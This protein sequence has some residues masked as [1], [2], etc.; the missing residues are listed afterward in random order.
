[1]IDGEVIHV[2][3]S[4]SPTEDHIEISDTEP[5]SG[6]IEIL[7]SDDERVNPSRSHVSEAIEILDDDPDALVAGEVGERRRV[8]RG[9]FNPLLPLT[10]SA[11][12]NH[13]VQGYPP[14]YRIARLSSQLQLNYSTRQRSRLALRNVSRRP[15]G[16]STG[17]AENLLHASHRVLR[18]LL[19]RHPNGRHRQTN[20]RRSCLHTYPI[21]P[22]TILSAL[23]QAG[24]T[25]PSRRQS[26][27]TLIRS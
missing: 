27:T 24:R 17:G 12:L 23:L 19:V 4:D 2:L 21:R 1:M 7:D 14:T 22:K 16:S 11:G 26:T 5:V 15:S 13:L 9:Q 18:S 3:D 10:A 6:P 20:G 25:C 8:F